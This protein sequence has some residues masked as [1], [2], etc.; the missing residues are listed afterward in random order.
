MPRCAWKKSPATPRAASAPSRSTAISS[1]YPSHLRGGSPSEF[2]SEAGG[3]CYRFTPPGSRALPAAPLPFAGRVAEGVDGGGGV[4]L[5]PLHP[6]RL[7]AFA[8]R[9]PPVKGRDKERQ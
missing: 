1:F 8:A 7:V 4:G 6:T 9:H 3:G 5:L 2:T